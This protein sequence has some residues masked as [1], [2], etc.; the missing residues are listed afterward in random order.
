MHTKASTIVGLQDTTRTVVVVRHF[1]SLQDCRLR[2]STGSWI[3]SQAWLIKICTKKHS[4][5]K[6]QLT[7]FHN[8]PTGRKSFI[9]NSRSKLSLSSSAVCIVHS[10]KALRGVRSLWG[11]C[12]RVKFC[13]QRVWDIYSFNL[14]QNPGAQFSLFCLSNHLI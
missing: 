1:I 6:A 8:Y 4:L 14:L 3:P 13:W 2:C 10:V 7:V 9:F 5:Q 12:A 11:I